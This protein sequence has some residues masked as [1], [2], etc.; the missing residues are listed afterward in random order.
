MRRTSMGL[1]D[2]VICHG[3]CNIRSLTPR[4]LRTKTDRRFIRMTRHRSINTRDTRAEQDGSREWTYD[5]GNC[6]G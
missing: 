2:Y 6:I 3:L 4:I 5:D 1:F